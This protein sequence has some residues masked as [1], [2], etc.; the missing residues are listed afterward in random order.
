MTAAPAQTETPPGTPPGAK[1]PAA[2]DRAARRAERKLRKLSEQDTVPY[3]MRPTRVAA[4]SAAP[5]C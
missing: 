4:G 2:P 5:S 1:A 3:G